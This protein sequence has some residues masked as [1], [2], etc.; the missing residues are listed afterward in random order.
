[1]AG[2]IVVFGG[3]YPTA[4][5]DECSIY[6]DVMV[7]NEGEITW[8]MFLKDLESGRWQASYSS[9]DKPDIRQTAA[10]RFDLIDTG[11]YVSI[12]IQFSRGCPFQCEFCDIIVMFGR[13]PRTKSPA[14]LLR[15]LDAL[16][17][18]G[19]RG[20][21]FIV[22]DNFIGNKK[23]VQELLPELKRWN[24]EHGNP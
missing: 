1:L 16:L 5:P 14:Q 10:P 13:R 3:P 2:K 21:V 8:P 18:T 12:P 7:L 9:P 19:Y 20:Q 23:D 22:D 24:R 4:C 6:C 17:A 11:D 15:E